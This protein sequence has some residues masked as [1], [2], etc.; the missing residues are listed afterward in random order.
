LNIYGSAGSFF[1]NPFVSVRK[2][3][4]LKQ[5]DSNLNGFAVGDK[6]KLHA[7]YLID[8]CGWKGYREGS[9]GVYEKNALVLI[10]DLQKEGSSGE[11]LSLADKIVQSVRE[12]YGVTLEPEVV[13]V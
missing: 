7:G 8:K 1:K 10:H 9:V 13:I 5:Q 4:E 6:V 2:Y 3:E 12:K 11:I